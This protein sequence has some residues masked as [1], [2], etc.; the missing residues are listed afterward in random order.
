MLTYNIPHIIYNQ[1][2]NPCGRPTDLDLVLIGRQ[3]LTRKIGIHE[4]GQAGRPG[5]NAGLNRQILDQRFRWTKA[6]RLG[7]YRIIQHL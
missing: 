2:P 3:G 4:P 1:G 5:L 6:G 7:L